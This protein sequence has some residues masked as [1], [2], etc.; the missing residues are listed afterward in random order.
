[1][2]YIMAKCVN[3]Q[4]RSRFQTQLAR[5]GE[6][7]EFLQL[8]IGREDPAIMAYSISVERSAD[9]HVY[10]AISNRRIG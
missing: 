3:E 10:W 7:S 9:E 6:R 1:M 8:Y 4:P 5:N 2:I